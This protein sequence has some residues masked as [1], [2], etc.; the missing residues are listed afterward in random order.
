MLTKR[1]L[2]LQ[3][4]QAGDAGRFLDILT[5]TEDNEVPAKSNCKLPTKCGRK[6]KPE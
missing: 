5:K 6:P 1:C 4:R 2:I 3:E